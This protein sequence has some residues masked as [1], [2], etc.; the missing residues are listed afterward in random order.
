MPPSFSRR[1]LLLGTGGLALSAIAV[2][3]CGSTG[4]TATPGTGASPRPKSGK[5]LWRTT[6][7]RSVLNV[8]EVAGTL[9][10][11]TDSSLRGLLASNGKE[12]WSLSGKQNRYLNVLAVGGIFIATDVLTF[13][14]LDPA[15]GQQMWRLELP[16]GDFLNPDTPAFT[17]DATTLYISFTGSSTR[18]P[19]GSLVAVDAMTG[20]R[21]WTAHLPPMA[22]PG[23]LAAGDGHV[24]VMPGPGKMIAFNAQTGA[25]EWTATGVIP[26]PGTITDGVLCGSLANSASKSGVV[27][28]GTS[29]GKVLW[30]TDVG[31]NVWGTAADT[32]VM[33]VSTFLGP[34]RDG[35]PGDLIALDAHTG[36]TIWKRHFDEGPPT[37]LEPAG[38]VLYTGIDAGHVHAIDSTTGGVLWS[39]DI[40]EAANDQL[41]AVVATPGA[42]YLAN[43][44]G[45]LVALTI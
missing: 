25:Q 13:S 19:T 39:Y 32:G 11:L 4:A 35:V 9:C 40:K 33:Y 14:A 10:A 5:L 30:T 37:T 6:L 1:R 16:R 34:T 21:K 23:Q 27:A 42:L 45:A 26:L 36:K 7:P 2:G 28:L 3:G 22:I 43:L 20:K 44:N 17:R 29:T 8:A 41:S 12:S 31:G 15:T 38:P 18:N 24:C